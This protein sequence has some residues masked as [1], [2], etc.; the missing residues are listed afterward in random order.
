MPHTLNLVEEALVKSIALAVRK[1]WTEETAS[2]RFNEF[3]SVAS[4]MT[5]AQWKEYYE[6][7]RRHGVSAL[8][9]NAVQRLPKEAGVPRDLLFSWFA[10]SE[11]IAKRYSKQCKAASDFAGLMR[12]NGLGVVILKGLGLASKYY[13]APE[14]RECGDIDVF[15]YE[16]PDNASNE[17][18]VATSTGADSSM[19]STGFES[20]VVST[21]SDSSMLS[22]EAHHLESGYEKCDGIIE[23]LHKTIDR[24]TEKHS[25]FTYD[26]VMVENHKTFVSDSS[27]SCRLLNSILNALI[28]K[29]ISEFNKASVVRLTRSITSKDKGGEYIVYPGADFNALFLLRHMVSHLAYE[30]VTLHNIVD[31]GLFL[32]KEKDSIDWQSYTEHLRQ[33]RLHTAFAVF[34]S[35]AADVIGADMHEL[36]DCSAL[37]VLPVLPD[38]LVSPVLP[39]LCG[40]ADLS[41][42]RGS[43]SRDGKFAQGIADF[44][45]LKDRVSMEVMTVQL[46]KEASMPFFKR[47]TAKTKRIFSN[48]WQYGSVNPDN[49]WIDALLPSIISH[50]RFPDKI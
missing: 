46:H 29:D 20:N 47:L 50:L 35:I 12:D 1:D 33:T 3:V 41:E 38:L 18:S 6:L 22:T 43:G 26:G 34:T 49:F 17:C 13:P 39:A 28:D 19:L 48:R 14:L 25:V 16:L 23:S 27:K 7:S 5:A 24:S 9:F 21:G 11:S 37:S 44:V 32:L 36:C 42:V 8:V 4:S 30:G 40:S 2:L 45:K 10:N 31:W 15:L